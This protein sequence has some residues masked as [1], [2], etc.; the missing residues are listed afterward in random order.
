MIYGEA[1]WS[2]LPASTQFQTMLNG[3]QVAY[4]GVVKT[5]LD[6]TLKIETQKDFT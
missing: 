2:E 3:E 6:E 5:V 4:S 1:A